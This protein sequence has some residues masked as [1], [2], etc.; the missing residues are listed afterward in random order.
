MYVEA[1]FA[2]T[3]ELCTPSLTISGETTQGR[4]KGLGNKATSKAGRG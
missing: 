4:N 1:V 3:F 2:L